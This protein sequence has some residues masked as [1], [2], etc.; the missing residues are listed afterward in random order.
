MLQ[1][2]VC[3]KRRREETALERSMWPVMVKVIQATAP[4]DLG[5]CS[6]QSQLQCRVLAVR[7]RSRLPRQV[8]GLLWPNCDCPG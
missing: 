2:R 5:T 3:R 8:G 6:G 1:A 4:V 7:L